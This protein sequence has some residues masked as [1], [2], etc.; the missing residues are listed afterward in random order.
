MTK[1]P[2]S[3][4]L[5]EENVK[6]EI[7]TKRFVTCPGCKEYQHCVEHLFNGTEHPFNDLRCYG[8]GCRTVISGTVHADGAITLGMRN[9][10][11][12]GF[13]LL[14]LRDL[15]LVR[16]ERFE[17]DAAEADDA[18]DY[19][20]HSHQCPTNLLWDVVAVY[21]PSGEPDQHGM[22]RYVARIENTSETRKIFEGGNLSLRQL[23]DLFG[24]DGE[25][26]ASNYPE[27]NEGLIPWIAEMQRNHD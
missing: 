1:P 6:A 27:A 18:D 10:R 8:E 16:R 15:Y 26:I 20:Y 19:F 12:H 21:G 22:I 4:N 25:P 2:R 17:S 7:T 13:A 24:T 14:K 5:P 11:P 9:T 23:L 3:R